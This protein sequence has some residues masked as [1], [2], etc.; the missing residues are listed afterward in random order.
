MTQ[1]ELEQPAK[2]YQVDAVEREITNIKESLISANSK[3]DRVINQTSGVVTNAQLDI[4]LEKYKAEIL[5][6]VDLKYEPTK[7]ASWWVSALV[8]TVLAGQIVIQIFRS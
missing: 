4:E 8:V 3:L 7:K 2:V 1:A 5:K 6:E